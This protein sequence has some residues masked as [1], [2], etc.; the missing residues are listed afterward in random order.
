MQIERPYFMSDKSWYFYNDKT[1]RFELTNKA[2]KEAIKSYNEFY[3]LV[4]NNNL[5][6]I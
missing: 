1:E 4:D 6:T 5:T 2:T 3:E